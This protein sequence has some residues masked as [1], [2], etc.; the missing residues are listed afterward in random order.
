MDFATRD[1]VRGA[2]LGGGL[3]P[4]RP[5]TMPALARRYLAPLASAPW[6]WDDGGE[7]IAWIDGQTIAFR[8]EVEAVRRP[9]CAIRHFLPSVPWCYC[10]PHAATAGGA[11]PHWL[12]AT[13]SLETTL[14]RREFPAWLE[15]LFVQLDAVHALPAE[16]RV[17]PSAKADLAEM[18]FEQCPNVAFLRTRRK[19][20]RWAISSYLGPEMLAPQAELPHTLDSVLHELRCLHE[21]LKRIDAEKLKLR[22]RT[23]L[24]RLVQPGGRRPAARWN[25]A[26]R[27]IARLRRDPELG[28]VARIA[29]QLLAAVH[30]PRSLLDHEDLPV[31]GISDISNRGPLDRLLLSELAHDDLTLAVRIA[32]SEALYLRRESPPRSP[33]KHRALLIDAGIRLWGVPRV[34]AAAVGLSLVAGSDRNICVDAYRACG[35]SVEPVDLTQREGLI[36]HL[37]ALEADAHPGDA[38]GGVLRGRREAWRPHGRGGGDRRRRGRGSCLSASDCRD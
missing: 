10:W 1:S 8:A 38:L 13:A 2:C 22:R 29:G 30:L 18:V 11:S 6:R 9:A 24:D 27:L 36:E 31:G 17:T 14:Q 5:L 16:L 19:S 3:S 26:R 23:G 7:V 20:I 25:R 33:P 21:G 28:G 34:F 4:C 12:I 37:E 35:R 32:R 15:G